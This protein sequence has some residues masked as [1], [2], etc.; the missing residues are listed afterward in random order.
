MPNRILVSPMCQ[1]S[2]ADNGQVNAWHHM[3][4]LNLAVSGAG[5]FCIEATAVEPEGRITPGCLGLWD[6]ATEAA[7]ATLLTAVRTYSKTP[8]IIQLAHAGRKGSSH[9]PWEGGQLIPPAQGGWVPP[10]PSAIPQKQGEAPPA[11]LNRAGMDAIRTKFV[12]SNWIRPTTLQRQHGQVVE[13][14]QLVGRG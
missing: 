1:Y 9:V 6:D 12:E 8:I 14:I 2:A 7:L 5:M 13:D 11:A 10:A 3:H 4:I